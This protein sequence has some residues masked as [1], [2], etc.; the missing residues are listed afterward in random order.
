MNGLAATNAFSAPAWLKEL[1]GTGGG[2]RRVGGRSG[3]G[4][5]RP[6]GNAAQR[7]LSEPRKKRKWQRKQG[8][9]EPS[10]GISNEL[11]QLGHSI[12][13]SFLMSVRGRA[14][15]T[16]GC[17]CA[18]P[19]PAAPSQLLQPAVLSSSGGPGGSRGAAGV[20]RLIC[21]PGCPLPR[22]HSSG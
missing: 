4:G 3:G 7:N 19:A 14:S 22:N 12:N 6:S 16:P 13:T 2:A 9:I 21:E 18:S 10:S 1:R 17:G 5:T 20:L 15:R 11:T 8:Q